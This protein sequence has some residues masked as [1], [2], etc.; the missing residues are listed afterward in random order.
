MGFHG[1]SLF[2]RAQTHSFGKGKCV[3]ASA[4]PQNVPP[5]AV[6]E[7]YRYSSNDYFSPPQAKFFEIW[8]RRAINSPLVTGDFKTRG[9]LIQGIRLIFGV[10]TLVHGLT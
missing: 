7:V 8:V 9:E 2:F 4:K 6:C 1:N 5:A 3:F 10:T